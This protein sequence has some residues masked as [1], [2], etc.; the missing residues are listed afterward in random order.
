MSALSQKPFSPST[1]ERKTVHKASK[2]TQI[3]EKNKI[4]YMI[5]QKNKMC[6]I[7]AKKGTK[8]DKKSLKSKLKLKQH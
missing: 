7:L 2:Q 4:F 6:G 5:G 8:T 1:G 3:Q